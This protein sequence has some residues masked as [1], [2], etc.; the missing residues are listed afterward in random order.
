MEPA[1]DQLSLGGGEMAA[2]GLDHV[3]EQG[4]KNRMAYYAER[5][6]G[7]QDDHIVCLVEMF[8]DIPIDQGFLRQDLVAELGEPGFTRALARGGLYFNDP[9]YTI[10]IPSMYDCMVKRAQKI[11]EAALRYKRVKE[12]Q[13]GKYAGGLEQGVQNE[14]R[15]R[16]SVSGTEIGY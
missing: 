6:K 2:E 5:T 4:R 13:Q 10:P 11:R 16:D 8:R 1:L 9:W 3:M 12:R 14:N 7:M 15:G